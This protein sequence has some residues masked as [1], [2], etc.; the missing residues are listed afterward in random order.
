MSLQAFQRAVVELTLAPHMVEALRGG[1]L[2][3]LA[4]YELT[5]RERERLIAIAGQRGMAV[6][7]T[8][9][10]GNRLEIIFEAFP[11]TCILLRPVLRAIVDELWAQHRPTHY[12]LAEEA[13]AFIA[14]LR[15]KVAQ[16]S[17]AIPYLPDVF[18]YEL[19]CRAL[20]LRARSD[21]DAELETIVMFEHAPEPL[22]TPLSNLTAPPA[23]LPR[24]CYRVA[25]RLRDGNLAY[26][27]IDA[28]LE[29][30]P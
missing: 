12:Q 22:L 4:D 30:L 29:R 21:P 11:M 20:I 6:H 27:V 13:D 3:A 2:A 14:F 7:R 9:A 17:L 28:Q 25:V 18:G 15:R 19:A 8:L 23:G 5:G 24:G 1:N 10:R 26:E 16:G